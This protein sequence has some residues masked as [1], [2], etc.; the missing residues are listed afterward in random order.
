MS[1]NEILVQ[2]LGSKCTVCGSQERLQLHHKDKNRKNNLLD[3]IEL[4]CYACH[5]KAHGAR[6]SVSK[7][8]KLTIIL[9]SETNRKLREYVAKKYPLE[10]Y[11]KISQVIEEALKQYIKR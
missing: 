7:M 3:N 5:R 1:A 2:A 10:S 6:V 4:L 8:P 11:G 9:T